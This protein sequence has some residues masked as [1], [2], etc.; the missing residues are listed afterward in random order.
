MRGSWQLFDMAHIW[1]TMRKESD[2]IVRLSNGENEIHEEP[3]KH[4]IKYCE[5]LL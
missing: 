5:L 1:K 2:K 4:C 3:G